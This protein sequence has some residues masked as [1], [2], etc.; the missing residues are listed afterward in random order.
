MLRKKLQGCY[1]FV[2]ITEEGSTS[3]FKPVV[4][5]QGAFLKWVV[6]LH[7]NST[8]LL[9]R[10]EMGR[11]KKLNGSWFVNSFLVHS[12]LNASGL[13][14]LALL[15]KACICIPASCKRHC[16]FG[17]LYGYLYRACG[18]HCAQNKLS[19]FQSCSVKGWRETARSIL[20]SI[21]I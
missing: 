3:L 12:A 21:I 2:L 5:S 10:W 13:V 7:Q 15:I 20:T 6:F 8:S 4:Q 11:R 9:I 19:P 14:L 1:C 17:K 16:I 18:K